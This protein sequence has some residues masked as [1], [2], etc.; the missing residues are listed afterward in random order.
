MWHVGRGGGE[1]INGGLHLLGEET[2]EGKKSTMGAGG[3]R[4][5]I[6]KGGGCLSM[7][8]V[9][10][11]GKGAYQWCGWASGRWGPVAL[12]KAA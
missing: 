6:L 2:T 5:K 7:R 3:Y 12:R 1:Y 11:S 4:G 9:F 10:E 8:G